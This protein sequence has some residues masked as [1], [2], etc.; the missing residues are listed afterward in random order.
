M[1]DRSMRL[2]PS[3]GTTCPEVSLF[4]S[5]PASTSPSPHRG[6]RAQRL[7]AHAPSACRFDPGHALF[8]LPLGPQDE[9]QKLAERFERQ[10]SR[11]CH[12]Y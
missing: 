5:L 4:C 1:L 8:V 6:E 2:A 12:H 10:E 3:D 9:V 7:S 11:T